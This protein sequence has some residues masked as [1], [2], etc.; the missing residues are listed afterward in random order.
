M[1]SLPI[2]LVTSLIALLLVYGSALADI[3]SEY[4]NQWRNLIKNDKAGRAEL[5]CKN[6]LSAKNTMAYVQ[7]HKC[8]TKVESIKSVTIKYGASS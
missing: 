5:L 1:T 7:A 8:L 4:A 6:W 3:E 2:K